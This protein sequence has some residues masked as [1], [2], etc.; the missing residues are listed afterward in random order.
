[1][2]YDPGPLIA[3]SGDKLRIKEYTQSATSGVKVPETLWTGSSVA[4]FMKFQWDRP[5]VLNPREGSGYL[6]FEEGSFRESDVTPQ[7][8]AK[9]HH[10]DHYAVLGVWSYGQADTGYLLE[11][12]ITTPDCEPTN[13]L[14]FYVFHGKVRLIQVDSTRFGK[15]TRRFYTEGWDPLDIRQGTAELAAPAPRPESLEEMIRDSV[16]ISNDYDFV[17]VDLYDVTEGVYFGDLPPYPT[18]GMLGLKPERYEYIIG[19]WSDLTPRNALQLPR[20]H[21]I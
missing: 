19:S 5:C 1:M 9:W 17:R 13:D 20:N 10:R 16:G 15:L 7:V 2:L 21:E 8:L 11:R 4:Y 18:G 3:V 6:A 12:R 14:R